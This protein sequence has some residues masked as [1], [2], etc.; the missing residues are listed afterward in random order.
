MKS[1]DGIRRFGRVI[2]VAWR[3][4]AGQGRARL[5]TAGQ[6]VAMNC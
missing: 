1:T 2:D 4:V 6:G 5:G 3:G